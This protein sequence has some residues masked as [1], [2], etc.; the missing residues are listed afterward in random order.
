MSKW[1]LVL[2]KELGKV[3]L[4]TF[5]T[6]KQA[7]DS[8]EYRTSLTRHLGYEPDLTYEIVEINKR[9]R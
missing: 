8:I 7:E 4:E 9:E 5:N 6:K 3:D 2:N 1:K